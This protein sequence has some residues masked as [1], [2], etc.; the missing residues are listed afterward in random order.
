LRSAQTLNRLTREAS[1]VRELGSRQRH[2]R[3]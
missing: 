3:E 1:E 2:K